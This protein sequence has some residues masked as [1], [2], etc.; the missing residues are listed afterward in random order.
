[1]ADLREWASET[2]RLAKLAE[3]SS[4]GGK[5]GIDT[6]TDQGCP[7]GPGGERPHPSGAKIPR[8][9]DA[10]RCGAVLDGWTDV[11]ILATAVPRQPKQVLAN[12]ISLHV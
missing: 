5:Q 4:T 6:H 8:G 1:M 2:G 7:A 12:R 11:A 10:S 9:G 3:D